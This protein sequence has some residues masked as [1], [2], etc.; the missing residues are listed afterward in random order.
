LVTITQSL[1]DQ[2]LS[3]AN[4]FLAQFEKAQSYVSLFMGGS[5]LNAIA[6]PLRIL[7]NWL[8]GSGPLLK[9]IIAG[10]SVVILGGSIGFWWLSKQNRLFREIKS[11]CL[12]LQRAGYIVYKKPVF[13]GNTLAASISAPDS[14]DIRVLDFEH[15]TPSELHDV[16]I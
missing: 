10:V 13:L 15:I 12:K 14:E 16:M 9:M 4:T 2:E 1:L 3:E 11:R 5:F 8:T 6:V 7:F